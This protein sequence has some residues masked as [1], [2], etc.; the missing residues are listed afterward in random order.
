M[1]VDGVDLHVCT[2]PTDRPEADGTFRWDRTTIVI[3]EVE[4]AG[5]RGLGYT[6]ADASAATLTGDP[7]DPDTAGDGV[8]GGAPPA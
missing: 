4:A 5:V 1:T 2:I 3:V 8:G 6:Y 7:I